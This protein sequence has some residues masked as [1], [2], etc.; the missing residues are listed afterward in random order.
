MEPSFAALIRP[1]ANTSMPALI[2]EAKHTEKHTNMDILHATA[3]APQTAMAETC[4]E[5]ILLETYHQKG[6]WLWMDSTL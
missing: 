3:I 4:Q 1:E 6:V 5:P 2:A